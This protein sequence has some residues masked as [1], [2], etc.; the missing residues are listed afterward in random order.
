MKIYDFIKEKYAIN[1][2]KNYGPS[3]KRETCLKGKRINTPKN[4]ELNS[5][6]KNILQLKDYK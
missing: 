1:F 2:N 6:K 5:G 3:K 4:Y